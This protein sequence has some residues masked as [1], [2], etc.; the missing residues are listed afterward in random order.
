MPYK[1][2]GSDSAFTDTGYYWG[3]KEHLYYR[4]HAT[5]YQS[6][7]VFKKIWI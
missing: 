7:I 6:E 5:Y 2:G 4:R 3:Q 1:N